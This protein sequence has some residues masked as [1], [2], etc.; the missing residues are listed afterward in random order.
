MKMNDRI[1]IYM[2]RDHFLAL[3]KYLEYVEESDVGGPLED[4][5][6]AVEEAH[7]DNNNYSFDEDD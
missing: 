2:N 6:A 4:L 1:Q 7:C 3:R 5:F